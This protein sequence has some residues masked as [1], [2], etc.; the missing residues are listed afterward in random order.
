MMAGGGT[1][2]ASAPVAVSWQGRKM[3]TSSILQHRRT[4]GST[5]SS[6]LMAARKKKAG[7]VGN[8]GWQ[9]VSSPAPASASPPTHIPL[10]V[11][12]PPAPAPAPGSAGDGGEECTAVEAIRALGSVTAQVATVAAQC[13]GILAPR[14]A[15]GAAAAASRDHLDAV[16]GALHMLSRVWQDEV[17]RLSSAAPPAAA[18]AADDDGVKSR[19]MSVLDLRAVLR[20]LDRV[21][22]ALS[23][24]KQ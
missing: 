3:Y 18:A 10:E 19:R 1:L 12:A 14:A 9:A 15:D 4:S 23:N 17:V 21:C 22:I 20:D 6:P 11:I 5:P 16:G 2:V 24:P 7:G 8:S 13:L